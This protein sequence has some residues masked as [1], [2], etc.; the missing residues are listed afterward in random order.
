[1]RCPLMVSA[2]GVSSFPVIKPTYKDSSLPFVNQTGRC[3]PGLYL[4]ETLLGV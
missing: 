1:M 2:L 4:T 3:Q